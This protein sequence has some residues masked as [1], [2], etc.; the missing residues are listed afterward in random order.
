MT[1]SAPSTW[2]EAV[3]INR[4]P[5]EPL[6]TEVSPRLSKLKAVHA[7]VFDVYGTLIISGSGDVGTIAEGETRDL[8]AESMKAAGYDTAALP[9]TPTADDLR[10]QI[11]DQNDRRRCPECPAPE[12]DILQAWR[13]AQDGT[14]LDSNRTGRQVGQRL[15]IPDQSDL[16]DARCSEAARKHLDRRNADGHCQQRASLYF[17]AGARTGH[18]GAATGIRI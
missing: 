8:V 10:Q 5:L 9:K 17:A 16:A 14:Q 15:R 11:A 4:R 1:N 13:I 12:V 18:R 6:P 7:V 2:M 3:I